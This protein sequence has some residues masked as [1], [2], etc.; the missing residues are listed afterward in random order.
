MI[1]TD[2]A[3]LYTVSTKRLNEQVKRN[4]KRFPEDFMFQLNEK[5]KLDLIRQ[6]PHLSKLKYSPSHPFA[7]TEHGAVM[8]A[9]ILNSQRAIQVNVQ[10]V[11]I[12]TQI[13]QLLL[14]HKDILLNLEILE[15]KVVQHDSD[16]KLV[17]KYLRELLNPATSPSRKIGFIQ[18]SSE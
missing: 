7:F 2:L 14:S 12:F 13:R 5:E 17:F 9:S 11:R 3:N 6:Y 1:D 18:K 15:K 16:I 4:S 8:V 10:I